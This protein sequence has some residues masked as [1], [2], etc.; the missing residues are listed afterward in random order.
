[1]AAA[2]YDAAHAHPDA[3]DPASQTQAF[4]EFLVPLVKGC[5][6]EMSLEVASP[7]RAGARRHGLHRGDRRGAAPTATP[8]SCPST[9]APPRS[10]PTTW[11]AARPRATAAQTARAIAAQ[12]E[13]TEARLAARPGAA[14]ASVRRP[15]WQAARQAFLRRGRLRRRP[16]AKAEPNAVFAGS[17]PYLMLAGTW[18]CRL[19]DG[20]RAA[21][22]RGRS[23]RPADDAD[24]MR[25]KIATARFYADH[26]LNRA[27]APARQHRRGRRRASMALLQEAF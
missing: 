1:V 24:F 8:G 14:G 16:Q 25:A 11:S 10:R 3:D 2:A 19:A 22:R 18:C 20:P 13:A 17:V 5:S 27:S 15:A 7:G 23:W 26:I 9:R 12:V 4:Y 6:T 21:G